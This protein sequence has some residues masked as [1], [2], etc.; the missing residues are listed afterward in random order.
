MDTAAG[1]KSIRFGAEDPNQQNDAAAGA[2][3]IRSGAEGHNQRNNRR[4]IQTG[5]RCNSNGSASQLEI[6][7]RCNSNGSASGWI[8]QLEPNLLGLA[9]ETRTNGITGEESQQESDAIPMGLHPS[10]G[11]IF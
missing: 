4:R 8:Q 9:Q 11:K 2:R 1:A 10:S 7:I 3:S 6:G 5:I